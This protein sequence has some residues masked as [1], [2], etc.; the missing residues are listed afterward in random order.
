MV[1]VELDPSGFENIAWRLHQKNYSIT[2]DPNSVKSVEVAVLVSGEVAGKIKTKDSEKNLGGIILHIYNTQST[3][4]ASTVTEVDGYFSCLGLVPG[5]YFIQIDK[6]QLK[7]LQLTT[8]VDK[9]HFTIVP[10]QEGSV[11]DGLEF[12]LLATLN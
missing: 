12:L 4:M 2:V 5:K 1:E 8:A 10:S 11:V 6:V 7:R 9:I 3:L